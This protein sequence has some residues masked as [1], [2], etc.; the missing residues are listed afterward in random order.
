MSG[1]RMAKVPDLPGWESFCG[2]TVNVTGKVLWRTPS[3]FKRAAQEQFVAG[4]DQAFDIVRRVLP[5]AGIFSVEQLPLFAELPLRVDGEAAGP[6]GPN[7]QVDGV[8]LNVPLQV[9]RW[10][11][12]HAGLKFLARLPFRFDQTA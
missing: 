2:E 11:S 3:T 12:L 1:I 10:E 8:A 7:G 9:V 4:G 5:V 6:T